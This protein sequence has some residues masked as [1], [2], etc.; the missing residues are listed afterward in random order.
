MAETEQLTVELQREREERVLLEARLERAEAR[1]REMEHVQKDAVRQDLE[2]IRMQQMLWGASD[3]V[4]APAAAPEMQTWLLGAHLS[5]LDTAVQTPEAHI[6]PQPISLMDPAIFGSAPA[7]RP[8]ENPRRAEEVSRLQRDLDNAR[9]NEMRALERLHELERRVAEVEAQAASL[10][11]AELAQ[12]APA[13]PWTEA[14]LEHRVSPDAPEVEESIPDSETAGDT[15]NEQ[16]DE[17]TISDALS[18]PELERRV[19]AEASVDSE[20]SEEVAEEPAWQNAETE[21][22]L[23]S[24]ARIL[25]DRPEDPEISEET[26]SLVSTVEDMQTPELAEDPVP[27]APTEDESEYIEEV[28]PQSEFESVEP[29]DSSHSHRS[30]G[31]TAMESDETSLEE[32]IAETGEGEEPLE[33]QGASRPG[34]RTEAMV[35][36]LQRLIGKKP[37]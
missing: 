22:A 37:E 1:L 35:E 13:L 34:N 24:F 23:R 14:A 4:Q 7:Q 17:N 27:T 10:Q 2:H 6:R 5:A 30:W 3:P 31:M 28:E 15:A 29:D 9:S 20:D 16:P 19:Q 25:Q 18:V 8:V 32:P 12:P 21:V 11:A 26:E 33:N 36:A